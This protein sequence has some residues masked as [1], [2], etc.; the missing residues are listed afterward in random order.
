MIKKKYLLFSL[1]LLEQKIMD[2][3]MFCSR[4]AL[5]RK[6]VELEILVFC[7]L[8]LAMMFAYLEVKNTSCLTKGFAF[9]Q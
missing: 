6:R 4:F 9:V 3:K 7:V 5:V 8:C 2:P 1:F